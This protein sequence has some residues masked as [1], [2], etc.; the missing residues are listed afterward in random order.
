MLTGEAGRMLMGLGRLRAD[1]S[2]ISNSELLVPSQLSWSWA[3]NSNFWVGKLS[4][5]WKWSPPRLNAAKGPPLYG[6]ARAEIGRISAGSGRIEVILGFTRSYQH[7]TGRLMTPK[8]VGYGR[9]IKR[10]F[11][12]EGLVPVKGSSRGPWIHLASWS[13]SPHR[14]G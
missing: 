5:S 12:C 1:R 4:A 8:R 2:E 7:I 10:Y 9:S 3:H 11:E 14:P 13:R 6:G